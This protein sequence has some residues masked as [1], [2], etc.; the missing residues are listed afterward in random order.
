[1]NETRNYFLLT[2]CTTDIFKELHLIILK[3]NISVIEFENGFIQFLPDSFCVCWLIK[4]SWYGNKGRNCEIERDRDSE[5]WI[6]YNST[7][8]GSEWQSVR[9]TENETMVVPTCSSM[10][11][12]KAAKLCYKILYCYYNTFAVVDSIVAI[13][14]KSIFVYGLWR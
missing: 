2:V 13:T 7:G 4:W 10:I 9:D 8:R 6:K 11:R 14:V 12:L 5:R 1:M 3:I